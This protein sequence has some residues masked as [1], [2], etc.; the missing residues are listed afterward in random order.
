MMR[1]WILKRGQYKPAQAADARD[2][3]RT[4]EEAQQLGSKRRNQ[5][6]RRHKEH[7]WRS[8]TNLGGKRRNQN[9]SRMT[10]V[11]PRAMISLI[12]GPTPILT[13]NFICQGR[14][15]H[16]HTHWWSVIYLVEERNAISM[17]LRRISSNPNI[18]STDCWVS[19]ERKRA[20]IEK[21]G[22]YTARFWACER[23]FPSLAS[24]T[25]RVSLINCCTAKL[26][27]KHNVF[28]RH[29]MDCSDSCVLQTLQQL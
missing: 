16:M 19:T 3:R 26:Q 27:T 24:Y 21:K 20:K 13:S 23:K 12:A 8:S 29:M 9:L 28:C 2:V 10:Q 14:Y 22:S 1:E 5:S 6:G 18:R 17:K 25:L 4:S 7:N 15:T 11:A